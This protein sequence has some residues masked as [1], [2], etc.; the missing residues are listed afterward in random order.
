MRARI[1]EAS[2]SSTVPRQREVP[3][4]EARSE[5]AKKKIIRKGLA[6]HPE[7]FAEWVKLREEERR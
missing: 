4:K 7:E 3:D 2:V 1:Q 5:P 6:V